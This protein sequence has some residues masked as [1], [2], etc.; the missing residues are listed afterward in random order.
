M[1]EKQRR[2]KGLLYLS[3]DTRAGALTR[4][5]IAG[6]AHIALGG[7]PFLHTVGA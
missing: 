7:L 1:I 5:H 3:V 4:R 6:V 2:D